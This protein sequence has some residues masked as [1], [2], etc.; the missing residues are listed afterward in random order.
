MGTKF[1]KIEKMI[2]GPRVTN[3]DSAE[4][5][6]LLNRYEYTF[7]NLYRRNKKFCKEYELV[8]SYLGEKYKWSSPCRIQYNTDDVHMVINCIMNKVPI[9][10]LEKVSKQRPTGSSDKYKRIMREYYTDK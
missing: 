9:E 10:V 4:A 3:A 6:D 8:H 2:I 1:S 5:L 7:S